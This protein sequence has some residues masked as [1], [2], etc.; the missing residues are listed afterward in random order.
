M[1]QRKEENDRRNYFMINFHESMGPGRD[2]T[3]DPW[4]CSQT[5]ICSQTRYR[6]RYAARYPLACEISILLPV[7]TAFSLQ[8]CSV[9]S[10][11]TK[12]LISDIN[13]D[14]CHQHFPATLTCNTSILKHIDP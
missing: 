10:V 1:N 6:L 5:R 13:M 12:T 3:R 7:E 8:H 14:I 11:F 2:R 4:N 9:T